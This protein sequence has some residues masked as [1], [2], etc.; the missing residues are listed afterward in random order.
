MATEG[1]TS[2]LDV[3]YALLQEVGFDGFDG[4]LTSQ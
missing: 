4:V 1:P 3:V 2:K